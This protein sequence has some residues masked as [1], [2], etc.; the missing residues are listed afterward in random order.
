LPETHLRERRL[1]SEG[2][3]RSVPDLD[4]DPKPEGANRKIDVAILTGGADQPY[5]YGLANALIEHGAAMDIIGNDELDCPEFH[6]RPGINFLNLRGDQS[7]DSSFLRKTFRVAA[8][9]LRLIRYSA[10]AEPGIF[11][12]LWNNKFELFDRTVLMLYY[13]WLK[14]RIVLTVHNVNAGKRDSNDTYLNRLTL[15]AQYRLADHIFV[16]TDKMKGE[17]SADLHVPANRITVI[18]F[19]INNAVPNTHLTPA[20]A[21]ERLGI[22]GTDRTILFFGHIAPYKGLEHLVLA[23]RQLASQRDDYKLIIAG[24]PKNCEKY[25]APIRNAIRQ[26]VEAGRVLLRADFIPDEETEIYFKA[27]DVFVLPYKHIYQSGVFFLGQS[28]GIPVLASDVGSL[29]DEIVEGQTGFVFQPEDPVDLR[30]A[31]E[32]YFSSDLYVNLDQRRPG[33]RQHAA[34]RHSWD[35]VGQ[36]TMRIYAHLLGMTCG[37]NGAVRRVAVF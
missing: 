30:R 36:T 15:K 12:I 6:G 35:A 19:G 10:G 17:L 14:K 22:R 29:K 5:A 33:I 26:D 9:Y 4:S 31:I 1:P 32:H 18:P 25:W 16:H 27:A 8:Y 20:M 3:E 28:F 34:E 37:S 23:F 2:V 11:H 21:R 13:K 24:R 7:T